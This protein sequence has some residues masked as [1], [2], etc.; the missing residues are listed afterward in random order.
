MHNSGLC[1]YYD[2]RAEES[3]EYFAKSEEIAKHLEDKHHYCLLLANMGRAHLNLGNCEDS[4]IYFDRALELAH[5]NEL[6]NLV[7]QIE[8][9]IGSN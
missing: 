2:S 7:S 1:L 5:E 6:T 8:K 3:L 4:K 9:E